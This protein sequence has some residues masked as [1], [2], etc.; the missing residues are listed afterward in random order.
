MR[1]TGLT[2]EKLRGMR[3]TPLQAMALAL[4]LGA[5]FAALCDVLFTWIGV[6]TAGQGALLAAACCVTFYAVPLLIHGVFEGSSKKV[7]AIYAAHE[8]L[9]S[10][11]IGA[12]VAWSIH[13]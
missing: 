5:L 9:L 13:A 10:A 8:T 4:V 1:E 6:R 2:E 3:T 7:W 11:I 12:I